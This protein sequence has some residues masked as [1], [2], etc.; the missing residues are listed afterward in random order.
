MVELLRRRARVDL[1]AFMR[2]VWWAPQEFVVGRHTRAICE[3]LTRAVEDWREGKTTYLLVTVPF[4]HGKS[5]IISRA[6]PAY[7]LGRNQDRQPDIIMSGYGF[8]LVRGFSSRVRK[9]VQSEGYQALFLG[10]KLARGA[11]RV[12]EWQV[13][14]SSGTVTAQGLGGAVTGK[15]AHLLIVDDYCRN[16]AEAVSKVYRDKVWDSFRNDLMTRLNAPAS[17]VIVCATP[18]HVDDVRGRILSEMKKSEEFP[19]FEELNFPAC[20]PGEYEYLF[21]ERF[22]ANWYKAQRATLGTQAA[23]LLDCNPK[24]EGGNRFRVDRVV[25]HQTKDGWPAGRETRGWDLASSEKERGGSDPDWTWGVRGLVVVRQ[26]P[27]GLKQHEVWLSA[28]VACQEEAPRRNALIVNTA[29]EDG[30]GVIQYIEAYGAYKDSYTTLR[31]LLM[32]FSVV[33]PSQLP[34]DKAAKLAALEPSFEAGIVHVYA[35][36]FGKFLDMWLEQFTDFP[37]G[38]HDDACDATAVMYHSQVSSTGSTFL[39]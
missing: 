5:D 17:I 26:L 8:N 7:F 11:N 18:W 28:G 12:D 27:Y 20:I 6:L 21:P 24:V 25:I 9:I 3:R 4:R 38:K 13:E 35:P 34:G 31:G 39:I 30:R 10:V 23:A 32:G 14:G 22:S 16:R 36:G 37:G 15:G 33:R 19:R 29:R 2:W 1:L